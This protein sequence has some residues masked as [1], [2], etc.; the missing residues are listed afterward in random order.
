LFYTILVLRCVCS[1]AIAWTCLLVAERTLSLPFV[2]ILHFFSSF[3]CE[4]WRL[5]NRSYYLI[6]SEYFTKHGC[7]VRRLC[8]KSLLRQRRAGASS[9]KPLSAFNRC[10]YSAFLSKLSFF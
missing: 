10:P 8:R 5:Y 7:Q 3:F 4:L 1:S 9:F 2:A 6:C